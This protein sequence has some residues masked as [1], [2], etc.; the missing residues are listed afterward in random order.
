MEYLAIGVIV[1]LVAIFLFWMFPRNLRE[2]PPSHYGASPQERKRWMEAYFNVFRPI[3]YNPRPQEEAKRMADF[4]SNSPEFSEDAVKHLYDIAM[5]SEWAGKLPKP[6]Y[7]TEDLN[8]REKGIKFV[9]HQLC[10]DEQN[11]LYSR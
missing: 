11:S 8:L 4:L 3:D 7:S 6:C 9:Y 10:V 1:V 2:A 5:Q